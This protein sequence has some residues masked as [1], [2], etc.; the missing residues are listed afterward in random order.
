[1]AQLLIEI[2]TEEIPAGY[3]DPALHAFSDHLVQ[4]LDENRIEHGTTSV[5]GTP[6][7]L[8]VMIEDVADRQTPKTLEQTGPP[9]RIA[10]DENGHPTVAAKKFAE[11]NKISP[12]RL[13]VIETDKGRYVAAR[14]TDPG[15]ATPTILK[16]SLAGII[17]SIPFPKTMRWASLPIHFARPIHSLLALLGTQVISCTVGDNKSGRYTFGHRFLHPKKIKLAEPGQYLEILEASWVIADI[18]KRRQLMEQQMTEAVKTV[19][20]KVL[21]DPELVAIVT[22][23]IEYPATVLGRFEDRFLELPREV[24]ITAMREHQRYFAVVDADDRVMPHFLAVNN[25]LASD[26]DLVK[27]GHERVLKARL[28]DARFFFRT[29]RKTSLDAMTRKLKSVLFQAE[30]GSVYDKVIRIRSIANQLGHHLRLDEQTVQYLDRAAFLSKSDLVSL[31][32]NEFP[33][34]QGVMGRIYAQSADEPESVSRAIEEHYRPTASGGALPETLPGSLLSLADKMDSVCGCFLIGLIPTGA[35]DPYALR[36]QGIGLLQIILENSLSVS[37][38]WLVLASLSTFDGIQP[39]NPDNNAAGQTSEFLTARLA[40]ILES[41]SISKDA[42]AAVIAVSRADEPVP[43]IAAKARS[44]QRLKAQPEF[45]TLAVGFKRVVNII[46]KAD[47]ADTAQTSVNPA[48]F[49]YET[50]TALHDAFMIIEGQVRQ[51]LD[52]GAIDRAFNAVA[53]L[54]KSVDRFFDDVLVMTEDPSLRRNRL[55]LLNQ[56]AQLFALLADFS[57]IST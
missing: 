55:A 14:K 13:S 50:E 43:V 8:S 10:F 17:L 16:N 40:H 31:M 53:D 27:Q 3:I 51:N 6:R 52:T 48:L 56:I 20:G 37:I 28:E 46:R 18:A 4:H 44:L 19:R 25:T 38:N 32:V 26:M 54:R 41:E 47:P 23:L 9:A 35:S 36:R 15:Q 12:A 1:M 21:P 5:F 57:K 7:R 29:D 49:E 33:K 30:L 34:L 39:T 22:H 11:K 45:D 42:V 24:L 2:G